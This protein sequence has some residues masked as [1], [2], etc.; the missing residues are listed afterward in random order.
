MRKI[1]FQNI[2]DATKMRE[3]GKNHLEIQLFLLSRFYNIDKKKLQTMPW[4]DIQ[5]L[6]KKLEEY[7][8]KEEEMASLNV[9]K[10][11]VGTR[12]DLLDL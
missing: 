7:L 3:Q 11:P 2:I 5:P 10:E 8:S 4:S 9:E 6:A 12:F 1:T